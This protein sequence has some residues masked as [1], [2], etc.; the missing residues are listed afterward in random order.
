MRVNG[1][2]WVV[3]GAG[4]GMGRELVLAMLA[5]GAK[6]AAVDRDPNA[7]A[8][9][10]ELAGAGER[11]TT[12]AVDITDSDAVAGLPQRVIADHGVVDGVLNNAGIVQPFES[13]TELSQ[14]AIDKVLGVNLG[15]TLAMTRAFLPHLLERP[16][17]HL[18]NVSSMG[19]FFPFPGQTIYGASKAAVKLLTEGLYAELLDT[20]VHVSVIYPGAIHTDI[21]ANSGVAAPVAATEDAKVPMTSPAKAAQII[22]RG[23]ERDKLHVHV[24][25][26]SA[27]M[28]MAIKV[29]PRAAIKLVKAAMAR[30]IAPSAPEAEPA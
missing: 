6:V 4:N 19:G 2:V 20:S 30:Q 14:A 5:K 24:G 17:A 27:L 25:L 9:T 26:D 12:Y 23:I 15:G 7:L 11:L 13:V 22:I 16:E 3:T 28:G 1:K 29:A 21:T 8:R 18:A 10:A